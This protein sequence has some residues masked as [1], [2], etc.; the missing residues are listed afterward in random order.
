M[1]N[2]TNACQYYFFIYTYNIRIIAESILLNEWNK[3]LKP[4]IWIIIKRVH[5]YLYL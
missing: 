1:G 5:S 4:K 3:I 2:H